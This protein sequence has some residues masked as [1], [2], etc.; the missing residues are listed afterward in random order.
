MNALVREMVVTILK[1]KQFPQLHTV[2][3]HSTP[4]S[5]QLV[6]KQA[7]KNITNAKTAISMLSTMANS[8]HHG[9]TSSSK[10]MQPITFTS[11]KLMA[12]Q[13]PVQKPVLPKVKSVQT[14]AQPSRHKKKSP[15]LVTQVVQQ[16]KK[17]LLQQPA[18]QKAPMTTSFTAQFAIMNFQE[19]Q[20]PLTRLLTLVALQLVLNKQPA[21][22]VAKSTAT[23]QTTHGMK[24]LS[25]PPQPA[26][27]KVSLHSLVLLTI[28]ANHAQ[29]Q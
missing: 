9:V 5:L 10:L 28:V 6:Q 29:K 18:Q 26:P 14:V 15:H 27:Q 22:F 23:L 8:R 3:Q 11:K 16:S 20:S 2:S 12:K 13:Q 24:V 7:Q 21:Q 17:T 19:K 25:Q 1:P 4:K